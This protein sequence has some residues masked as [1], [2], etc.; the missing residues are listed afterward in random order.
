MS[1]RA[2]IALPTAKGY[3]T[4]W[5]WNDGGPNNLGRE[6][7]TYFRDEESVKSLI[8]TKSF[9]G[10]FGP[11]VINDFVRDGDTAICLPNGRWLLVHPH[12]G[13]VVE[14]K[15]KGAF[16]KTIEDMLQC[17]LNYV[18]VFADGKWETHK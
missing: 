11:R 14:G 7:R 1:T 16:F 12:Q 15:G 18:Y 9:S 13:G 17:D 6:L 8:R 3:V 4:A 2:I 10:I 5:C